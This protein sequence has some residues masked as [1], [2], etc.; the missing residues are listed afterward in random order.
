ML[1]LLTTKETLR[2]AADLKLNSKTKKSKKN[3][4]ARQEPV[5]DE[6]L[7]ILGLEKSKHTLVRD[8][9]GGEKKRLSIG[10]EL[11]TNPPVI[12]LDSSSSLQVI[13]HL[14]TLAKSGRI[15][16]C[17][18][19]QPSSNLFDV[20]DDVFL[21]SEG[22]CLYSGP[23][24]CMKAEFEDAGFHF[25]KYY[26][27]AD[28][29]IEVA[30]YERGDN[31][32]PLIDKFSGNR[33][34][35]RISSND[36]EAFMLQ[37]RDET[38]RETFVENNHTYPRYPVPLWS[39][40]YILIKR[41]ILCSSRDVFMLYTRV[42]THIVVGLTIGLICYNIGNEASKTA[43]NAA[44]IFYIVLCLFMISPFVTVLVYIP[45]QV[46]QQ[47]PDTLYTRIALH[48]NN[49]PLVFLQL[50]CPTLLL[51][52]A[53]VLTNQ[54]YDVDRMLKT[55]VLCVVITICGQ[56]MG[57]LLGAIFDA[58]LGLFMIVALNI[59]MSL[60]SGFFMRLED[61]PDY[62]QWFTYV[63]YFRHSFQAEM[64]SIYGGNRTKLECSEDFCYFTSPSKVLK[65]FNLS[66][67]T[68]EMNLC[69]LL[70]WLVASQIVFYLVLKW[71]IY[72]LR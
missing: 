61:I 4:M 40:I 48:G 38:A 11:L 59:P 37:P 68:Y 33:S 65:E 52:G 56:T 17:T 42:I 34:E 6:I 46:R 58:Q 5:I 1:P 30:C 9:S 36:E 51:L 2:I 43:S 64:V 54:P 49:A 31:I 14:K 22:L 15:V 35:D 13:C 16:V 25:P 71:R 63:S 67:S 57:L 3:A 69:A 32:Q 18:I 19:H 8:L 10:V 23:V 29:A 20:F 45:Y 47:I 44:C 12:G 39:Q 53:Y 55:W 24:S 50:I 21:I 7:Q 41:S 70:M 62:L 26:N 72:K 28:F 66:E 27:R 60:F